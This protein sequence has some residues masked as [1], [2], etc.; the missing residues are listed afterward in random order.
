MP[1]GRPQQAP[2]T[3]KQDRQKA[4]KAASRHKKQLRDR[5]AKALGDDRDPDAEL[6]RVRA[7]TRAR[8]TALRARQASNGLPTDFQRAS[9]GLPTGFPGASHG[10]GF[11]RASNG[12]PK[13]LGTRAQPFRFSG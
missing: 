3:S 10:T 2:G 13:A 7:L 5:E 1:R 12:L 4:T 6:E 11:Q 8:V 9:H